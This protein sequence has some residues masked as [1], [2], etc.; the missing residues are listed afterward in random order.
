MTIIRICPG[1]EIFVNEGGRTG[2]RG[3]GGEDV[4]L[5]V[6]MQAQGR[7]WTSRTTDLRGTDD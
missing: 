6:S 4:L 7:P 1:D 3:G 5:I 2:R